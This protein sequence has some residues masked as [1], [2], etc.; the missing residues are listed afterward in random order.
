[1]GVDIRLGHA[2]RAD[3]STRNGAADRRRGRRRARRGRRGGGERR[4]RRMPCAGSCRRSMRP[5]WPDA[6]DR[7]GAAVLLDLH[8]LSRH[9]GRCRRP[10][11]TTRSSW[12][13]DYERN[14]REISGGILPEE[15]SHLRAACGR[16]RSR[17]GAGRAT[18][19]ST[20]WCRCRTCAPTSTGAAEAPRYR[21]LVLERLAA[22]RARRHREPHPLRA[23]G[24][25]APIGATSSRS[26]E[27]ATFN[28]AHDLGADALLP[29]A[30]PLR[31]AASTWSAAAPIPA[32]GCR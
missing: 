3:R 21:A 26:I 22:A 6:Q 2:G 30:Q 32:A 9:R 1:M 13:R 18:P 17:H 7:P 25:A 5:R 15:P 31:A 29:P 12:P 4:F 27:G 16:Y 24:D 28:L 19:A 20:C 14:I 10:R 8:A 11:R 23:H